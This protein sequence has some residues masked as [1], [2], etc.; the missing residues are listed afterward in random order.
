MTGFP[1]MPMTM[2]TWLLLVYCA[3]SYQTMAGA[4]ETMRCTDALYS[5]S[6]G[7]YDTLEITL[8][9]PGKSANPFDFGETQVA[10]SFISPT[11]REFHVSGF[12]DGVTGEHPRQSIWNIR[13]M[14]NQEGVWNFRLTGNHTGQ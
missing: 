1:E 12:F 3:F 4:E 13:F 11:G 9:H 2:K 10:A 8:K 6:I 5:K 14:P 7:P